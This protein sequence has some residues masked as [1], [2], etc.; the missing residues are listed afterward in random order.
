MESQQNTHPQQIRIMV[1]ICKYLLDEGVD[2]MNIYYSMENNTIGEAAL[3]SVA[4]VGE[5]KYT[6]YILSEPKSTR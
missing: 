3:Q 5:E 6:R 4:E 1:D 2:N